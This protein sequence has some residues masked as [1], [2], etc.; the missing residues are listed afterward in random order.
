[1]CLK[2]FSEGVNEKH[3][4]SWAKACK[5]AGIPNTPLTPHIDAE[6]LAH[7]HLACNGSMIEASG[8]RYSVPLL[9][10]ATLREQVDLYV[11]QK[12]FPPLASLGAK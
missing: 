12:L 7:N 11:E 4:E 2:S 6:L 3:M 5:R 1:M 8:F 10:P 9:T